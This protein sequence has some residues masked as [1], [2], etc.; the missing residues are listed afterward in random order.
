MQIK[1][2]GSYQEAIRGGNQQEGHSKGFGFVTMGSDGMQI[3]AGGEFRSL[4]DGSGN[5]ANSQI[6][7]HFSNVV[8]R[9]DFEQ[10]ID[11]GDGADTVVQLVQGF[12]DLGTAR[13][14]TRLGAGAD[15]YIAAAHDIYVGPYAH[16][17]MLVD[18][19]AGR[20]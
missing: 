17:A 6:V 3:A 12:R 18:G 15:I 20:I 19:G 10:S 2:D 11:A 16:L 9:G 14:E 5:R 4:I 7:S 8:N 13:F 1:A